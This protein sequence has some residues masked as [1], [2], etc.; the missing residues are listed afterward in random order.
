MK[1]YRELHARLVAAIDN[2]NYDLHSNDSRYLTQTEVLGYFS[3]KA[4]LTDQCTVQE[5]FDDTIDKYDLDGDTGVYLTDAQREFATNI[6][7]TVMTTYPHE[8]LK[9]MWELAVSAAMYRTENFDDT[10]W[11]HGD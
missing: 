3:G 5:A 6:F 8:S 4:A 9:S 2:F 7:P 10:N 1:L 11:T